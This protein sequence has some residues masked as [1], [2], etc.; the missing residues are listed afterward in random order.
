MWSARAVVVVL[1]SAGLA[2]SHAPAG[3]IADEP[4]VVYLYRQATN[5]MIP[6]TVRL[7][8]KPIGR[9]WS[10]SYVRWTLRPGTYD[11]FA[12]SQ[13]NAASLR[14]TVEAGQTRFVELAVV[15]GFQIRV[16]TLRHRSDAEGWKSI[17]G[18]EQVSGGVR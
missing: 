6:V 15:L 3:R 11:L 17:Q 5:P 7:D 8:G 1:A 13:T 16:V 2:S 14:V 12:R 4:G 9:L 18:L 10:Q